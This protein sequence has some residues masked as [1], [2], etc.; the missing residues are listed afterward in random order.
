MEPASRSPPPEQLPPRLYQRRP[1]CLPGAVQVGEE[2]LEAD[3]LIT[4]GTAHSPG[5]G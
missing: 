4:R 3:P 1:I 2:G 5:Q